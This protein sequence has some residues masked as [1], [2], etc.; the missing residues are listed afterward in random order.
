MITHRILTISGLVKEMNKLAEGYCLRHKLHTIPILLDDGTIEPGARAHFNWKKSEILVSSRLLQ[1]ILYRPNKIKVWC[2]FSAVR[3]E[4]R[5]YEQYIS[6]VSRGIKPTRNMFDENEAILTGRLWAD[7]KVRKLTL[8]QINPL[9]LY[10]QFHGNPPARI[11][12][13]QYEEPKGILMKIGRLVSLEYEPEPPST[14]VGTRF[15]HEMGDT[16]TKVLKSNS[17][18]ASDTKGKNLYILR[19]KGKKRPYFSERGLIG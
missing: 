7:N 12:K 15:A 8:E 2:L 1:Y 6:M 10:E 5:H 4:L 17:I 19:D 9:S 16:G 3:H 13:V 18:L 11:R 14:H